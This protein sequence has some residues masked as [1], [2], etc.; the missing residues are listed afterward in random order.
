MRY[1]ISADWAPRSQSLEFLEEFDE[2][3]SEICTYK[4]E[5]LEDVFYKLEKETDE[6]NHWIYRADKEL[7]EQLGKKLEVSHGKDEDGN[8]TIKWEFEGVR[9]FIEP[10]DVDE[11]Q[12]FLDQF[13][14]EG[15]I[16]FP[17]EM[18]FGFPNPNE[19][20]DDESPARSLEIIGIF[21]PDCG[22]VK[23]SCGDE[24]DE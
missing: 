8:S 12:E 5:V 18:A 22:G 7:V 20:L 17:E 19:E 2:I 13:G 4:M 1:Y 24:D 3:Q 21:C 6:E 15:V 16:G 10:D 23:N 9:Y 14:G 11:F